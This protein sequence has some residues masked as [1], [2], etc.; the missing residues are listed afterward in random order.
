MRIE[1]LPV[2]NPTA[3]ESMKMVGRVGRGS[4][5]TVET[6]TFKN[7]PSIGYQLSNI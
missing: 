1:A 5:R 3:Q 4:P 6:L 7:F 2:V